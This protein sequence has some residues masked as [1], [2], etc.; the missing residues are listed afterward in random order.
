MKKFLLKLQYLGD[1]PC[2]V[3]AF[4]NAGS[5]ESISLLGRL[6]LLDLLLLVPLLPIRRGQGANVSCNSYD[7]RSELSCNLSSKK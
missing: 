5:V 7:F 2:H 4:A 1:S 6:L 3:A